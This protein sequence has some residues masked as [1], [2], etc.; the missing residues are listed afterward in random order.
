[1]DEEERK[2]CDLFHNLLWQLTSRYSGGVDLTRSDI[3]AD[4]TATSPI[5][6]KLPPKFALHQ[7]L[8]SGDFFTS[9]TEMSVTDAAG[10]I[11]G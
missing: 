4:P 8:P 10:L 3:D 9:A 7:H 6:T 1:M 11:T 5:D 2:F